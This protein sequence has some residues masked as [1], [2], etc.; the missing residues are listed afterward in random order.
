MNDKELLAH[1]V[2][3]TLGTQVANQAIEISKL[4][5][6]NQQLVNLNKELQSKIDNLTKGDGAHGGRRQS[7]ASNK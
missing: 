1:E 3:A 2:A 6:Q 5:L 7:N 4:K